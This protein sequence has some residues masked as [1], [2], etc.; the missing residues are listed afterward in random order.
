MR[1]VIYPFF[2]WIWMIIL[3]IFALII[4]AAIKNKKMKAQTDTTNSKF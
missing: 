3:S 1:E 2:W 4:A